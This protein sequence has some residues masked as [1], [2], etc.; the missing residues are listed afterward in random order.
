VNSGFAPIT[1]S[2]FTLPADMSA[3][4]SAIDA[5]PFA[6]DRAIGAV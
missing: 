1:M 2:R 5:V 6:G 3:T 4:S